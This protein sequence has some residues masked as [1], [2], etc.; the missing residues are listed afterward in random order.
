[1]SLFL[2]LGGTNLTR[3]IMEVMVLAK[4]GCMMSFIPS[5]SPFTVAMI[6]NFYIL[7]PK[8]KCPQYTCNAWPYILCPW[9]Q[10]VGLYC[11]DHFVSP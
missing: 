10:N 3:A 2:L 9:A 7:D 1:M 5:P 6:V 11:N 4:F 8:C